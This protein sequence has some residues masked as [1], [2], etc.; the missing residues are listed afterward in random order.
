M[1][2][3]HQTTG[4]RWE[5]RDKVPKG[6]Q[7]SRENYKRLFYIYEA[8][9]ERGFQYTLWKVSITVVLQK[10]GKLH[11][12][13]PKAYRPIA[14]LNTMWKILTA[15]VA[16]HITFL[17]KKHELLPPNHFSGRP[18]RTTSDALHV[19]A[20]KIKD[21]WQAGKVTAVLFL[22]IEGAF[23]NA[24]LMK[25]VHNLRKCRIPGK[26]M[27]FIEQ[28]LADRCT[29]LK[30]DGHT[31][32]PIVL[33]NGIGKGD[34]L[35]MVLYQ[36]YNADLLNIPRGKY[37]DALAYV[38]DTIMV[39]TAETFTE[40]HMM[41]ADMMGQE[42]G[43]LDWSRAHNSP[44]EYTKLALI[45]FAHRSSSKARTALQL[46]QRQIEP[47]TSTK[48]LGIV[49][50]QSL[51]WKAQQAYTVAK[52]TK[53]AAQIRRLARPSWGIT[54]RYA[55]RL[56]ISVVLP[57]ILYV[58]DIWCLSKQGVWTRTSRIGPAKALNQ[59]IT[60]QRAGMLA[61]T[62]GHRTLATD[63]LNMHT[64]LLP[65]KFTVRKWCHRALTRIAVL[66]KEHP[67]HKIIRN[68]RMSKV[69]RHKGP[70]HHLARWFKPDAL[71]TKKIPT[72]ARDPTKIGK[73]PLKISIADSREESIKEA[74]N[75]KEELQ[76]Y[77]DGS[78]LEGK[79]GAAAILI[80]KGRHTQTLHYHLRSDEEHTVHEAKAVG[81]LLGMHILNSRKRKKVS[82]AIS[83][84]NQAAIKAFTLD[85]RNPGHHLTREA[86]RIASKI[87]KDKKKMGKGK[88]ALT[89]RW[90]AGHE[91]IEGN[92]LVDREAKEVAKGHTSDMKLLPS[93]LR[94]P[95]LINSSAVK[96]MHNE[97]LAKEWQEDWRNSK[98]GKAITLI[99]ESMP[100][101]KFLKLLS[102]P[103]L[104]RTAAS[105]VAQLRLTHFLLNGYLK[106]IGR[107]DSTRCLAC[108]EDEED[109]THFLLRCQ[110]YAHERW[111]LTQ[112][113]TKKRK[114]LTLQTI[115]GDPQ[116]ILP[117]AAYIQA[118]G[119][120]MRPGECST[121]QTRNTAR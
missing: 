79:V 7:R 31:L 29:T 38:D 15:I 82:A 106:R 34:P 16:S 75:V 59:I 32:E 26:Y 102:N 9:L 86:L 72:V 94:K 91:G 40:A 27:D 65:T 13:V 8:M 115:L 48:Y 83:V 111:P 77:S 19:L 4:P 60:I 84:D 98:Q 23:P 12:D 97:S 24:V 17:T 63:S 107:V 58:A 28:M 73:I 67:L 109:I 69:K 103:K 39:A 22:D 51:G 121:N 119:R 117:L 53:W 21:T 108:R 96:K 44:L 81:I 85:L 92:E 14:L 105:A 101:S 1:L 78:A 47:S 88:D 74:A 45:D 49:V 100:S 113:T 11:Y 112:H 118:T 95:M 6:V 5:C 2:L 54:P 41:L 68:R 25:L 61:I 89:I 120:F 43:V 110:N 116:F 99:D 80:H 37:K 50:D 62:G 114:P 36:Y 104:S 52:G 55:K 70:L 35:L 71:K 10:P 30:Y 20:H 56:Y 18:G 42:G 46:P 93:Y 66:P 57:Q 76:I 33:D 3:P 90:M 64:H 87:S